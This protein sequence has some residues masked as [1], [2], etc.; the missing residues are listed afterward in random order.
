MEKPTTQ[1]PEV[2]TAKVQQPALDT[3]PVSAVATT[4][5]NLDTQKPVVETAN[6]QQ[7]L[8]DEK[9]VFDT[10]NR[11]PFCR[12]CQSTGGVCQIDTQNH[13]RLGYLHLQI[14]GF[15]VKALVDT[16]ASVSVMGQSLFTKINACDPQTILTTKPPKNHTTVTL[17]DG[18]TVPILLTARLEFQIFDETIDETFHILQDTHTTILGW[19]FFANND[20]T[21][22]CKRRLLIREN[23]TF[24][25]N[26]IQTPRN[27]K[28][29][30]PYDIRL[31]PYTHYHNTT[32]T[33]R[34]PLLQG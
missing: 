11:Q 8:F 29:T 22:D 33:T 15:L 10:H 2:V 31:M 4:T 1:K 23:C 18:K 5:E 30:A 21:I 34:L 25:I 28:Y 24:Q 27:Q 32:R 6:V 3:K 7:P 14:G 9:P 26:A 17:A 20:L 19:P 12:E 16:G 13:N